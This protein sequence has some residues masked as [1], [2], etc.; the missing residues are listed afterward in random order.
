MRLSSLGRLWFIPPFWGLVS[1]VTTCLNTSSVAGKPPSAFQMP[2]AHREVYTSRGDT[3][4][5]SFPYCQED[6]FPQSYGRGGMVSIQG[7]GCVSLVNAGT[8]GSGQLSCRHCP[9]LLEYLVT[10]QFPS[11]QTAFL[12]GQTPMT[13]HHCHY[14]HF[15]IESELYADWPF[16]ETEQVMLAREQ[17]RGDF[18]W[19]TDVHEQVRTGSC[20]AT[21]FIPQ[22]FGSC[23]VFSM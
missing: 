14:V 17:G 10:F 1:P 15:S 20:M 6:H 11:Q 16:P 7:S 2:K 3:S 18:M 8:W 22:L 5:L 4:R 23:W 19:K 13:A 21:L 12:C 9:F